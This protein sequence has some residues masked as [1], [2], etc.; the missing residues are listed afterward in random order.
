MRDRAGVHGGPIDTSG[1]L[2]EIRAFPIFDLRTSTTS[3]LRCAEISD[4]T[5]CATRRVPASSLREVNPV[6]T[7]LTILRVAIGM[8]SAYAARGIVAAVAAPLN[9]AAASDSRAR[10]SYAELLARQK[11]PPTNPVIVHIVN[12]PQGVFVSRLGELIVEIGRVTTRI[13]LTLPD[14]QFRRLA[15]G[16]LP[17]D[18]ISAAIDW[19]DG[20]VAA[21]ACRQVAAIAASQGAFAFAE[22]LTTTEAVRQCISAGFRFGYGPALSHATYSVD[23]DI[24]DLPLKGPLAKY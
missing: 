14:T 3:I 20:A 4:P 6:E 1:D 23:G 18:G 8:A 17:A 19:S 16:A 22:M 5:G 15:P 7:D 12:V 21:V 13:F 2:L 10:R 11:L 9:Y 24:P